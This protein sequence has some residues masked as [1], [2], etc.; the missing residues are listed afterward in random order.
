MNFRALNALLKLGPTRKWAAACVRETGHDNANGI[1]M[2]E[3]DKIML[4][5]DI[6]VLVSVIKREVCL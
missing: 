2:L 4:V 6:A 3:L 1:F 5:T